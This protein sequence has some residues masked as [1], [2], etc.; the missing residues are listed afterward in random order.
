MV[1]SEASEKLR[2]E[3]VTWIKKN[4]P[5]LV[6]VDSSLEA[7]VDVGRQWQ[8]K[9][10]SGGWLGLY[11]P[12]EFGGRGLSL[13]EEAIIQEELARRGAPQ[14]LGLF[15][16]TMVGPVLIKH[17][18]EPQKARFLNSILNGSNI[19]CQGFSEPGAGSDLA[20][21]RTSAKAVKGG[22][23]VSGQKVWTSFAQISEWCFLICRT[24]TEKKK[25]Q[26]LTY[27]L[28][29]MKSPG[30]E[31]RPLKQITGD[32]EFNE[33]FFDSVFVPEE[34]IVGEVGQGWSIAISTLM[35]ERVILTFARHIQSEG[36]LRT[37]L[38]SDRS[39]LSPKN[40]DKL[41]E[42][43]TELCAV[44]ALAYEHLAQYANGK[45]PGAEGSLDKLLWSESFQKLSA[46]AMEISMESGENSFESIQRYLYSRGRTIAAGT[47]EIQ[48]NIIAERVLDLPRLQVVRNG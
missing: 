35:F 6:E 9:L 40:Q 28:V 26:G 48:R 8:A 33:V 47:S 23:L 5:P 42:C 29:D 30:I 3:F 37:I 15:G 27:M 36:I 10:A 24:S 14:I 11:W 43:I 46:L 44:R 2:S 41:A 17:G 18:T 45:A 25:H 20:N 39:K 38:K 13:L 22:F 32:E 31:V 34:L 12:K 4:P 7:F 21:V 19:W 1:V 16:L